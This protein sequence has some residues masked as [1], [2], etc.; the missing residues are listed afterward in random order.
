MDQGAAHKGQKGPLRREEL[1]L[2]FQQPLSRS[3]LSTFRLISPLFGGNYLYS[4]GQVHI[5]RCAL[6]DFVIRLKVKNN[7]ERDQRER[8]EGRQAESGNFLPFLPLFPPSP[9]SPS[10]PSPY[11]AVLT[12]FNCGAVCVG[13][14]AEHVVESRFHGLS[15]QRRER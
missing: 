9:L 2:A 3:F 10:L 11:T 4:G 8:E 14:D 15:N 7:R 13:R 1:S 12:L 5:N 6:G